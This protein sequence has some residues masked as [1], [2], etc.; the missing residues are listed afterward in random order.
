MTAPEGEIC[1]VEGREWYRIT[2]YDLLDPFLVHIATIGDQWMFVSSSGALTTG[3]RSA[4]QALFPYE[5]DDRLHRSGNRTGPFTLIRVDGVDE[6]WEPFA[7]HTPLGE[8]RRTIAK[9][10]VGDRLRFEEHHPGL[11]L[12]FRYTWSAAPEVGV[13]RS[14]ELVR[15]EGLSGVR[16]E[17]LDGLLDVL[18]A[19]VQLE[20]QQTSS[21]LV[22]A[23]RRAELDAKSALALFTLEAQITD[24]PDPAESLRA[25][26]VWSRGLPESVVALSDRQVR[27]F[28][29]GR[30]IESE[31]LVT[32]RKGSF[33]VSASAQLDAEAPLRWMI[34]ADTDR[35]HVDVARL[36]KWLRESHSVADQVESAT[37]HARDELIRL[38]ASADA[39]QQTADRRVD[40]NHYSNVLYNCMRGGVPTDE[41]R[42]RIADVRRL[43]ASR[44]RPA[45]ARLDAVIRVLPTMTHIDELRS[46]TE[47]DPDLARLAAEYLPLTFSR[48]H[49]DPSRPWNSFHIGAGR[50]SPYPAYEGNW[51]DIFQNW[52]ALLV[53]FPGY[54]ASVIAKFLNAS[55]LD[56]HNPYRITSEGVDWEVPED[57]AWSNF[58]YWGDHQ[59]V[60][61]HRLLDLAQRH[62]P[63]LLERLLDRVNFS[64]ANVPY[65]I[66]PYASLVS[67]PKHTIEFDIDEQDKIEG[68]VEAIGADGKLVLTD[69]QRVHHASMA[70]KLIVPALAK[71]SNLVPGGGIWLNTQRPEWNDANNALTGIGVSVVTV[72]H[73][74]D[75]LA[76]L[77]RLFERAPAA[78]VPVGKEL[79]DWLRDVH[80]AFAAHA[81]LADID[82]IDGAGRRALM[83]GLGEAFETY[84]SRVYGR[85]PGPATS[86]ALTELRDLLG[87]ARPH[88]DA[89]VASAHR[90]DGLVDAYRVLKFSPGLAEVAP[91]TLMLEGQVGFLGASDT[92]VDAAVAVAD[93]MFDSELY[94]ADQQSFLLQPVTRRPSFM[95][96]NHVPESL[97]GEALAALID[98]DSGIVRRDADGTVRFAADLRRAADLAEALDDLAPD[99]D[100]VIDAPDG[101]RTEV[102]EAYEAVFGH[103]AFTGRSQTMY[104]YEGIGS[105]YWHMVAKLLLA[106]QQRIEAAIEGAHSPSAVRSLID[107]YGAVRAGLGRFKAPAAHGAFPLEPYSHT[108]TGTGAQQPG[109]TGAAKEGVLLRWGELGVSVRDGCVCFRPYL[110]D[111]AEFLTEPQPWPPLGPGA[112]LEA[113]SL[114]FTYCGVPIEYRLSSGEPQISVTTA[115]G[116]AVHNGDQL[117]LPTS[118]QLFARTGAILRIVVHLQPWAPGIPA[119]PPA[120]SHPGP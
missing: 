89:V 21:T 48:R 34:V 114:G 120:L 52:E 29:S 77:D 53:S 33:L 63:G 109:M 17:L 75:Y 94:R 68:L 45:S 57:G 60:Y 87:A 111:P 86:V 115:G 69:E 110:L 1:V 61:L 14:C 79:L 101:G 74:R 42:V 49:G 28:R 5:T 8:V 7:P 93:A 103:S 70:E 3:R 26:V 46:A 22:D 13:V 24:R 117:D 65:R 31:H 96:K 91:L 119:E 95:E 37:E 54:A 85:S 118:Q 15:S 81:R 105:I 59:I 84:R 64:Y 9:T 92:D 66:K 83:D 12:T 30:L 47:A 113:G 98:A 39:L 56:G 32:G 71:L 50:G 62:Q 2:D 102:V 19:D 16:V 104:G 27:R 20:V 80:S 18:P 51:R 55:T 11:G 107:R 4:D 58:G 116:I 40:I 112:T 99:L 100:D 90:S 23:Y 67:H 78:E 36:E 72:F 25:S 10:S 97:V 106:L 82:L 44:N 73:L 76:F 41:H 38:A 43:V 108:P 35:D 6:A 88:L